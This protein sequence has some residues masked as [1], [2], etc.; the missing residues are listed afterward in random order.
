[1]I[2]G[3]E[4]KTMI[5]AIIFDLDGVITDSAQYHYLAWKELA[6]SLGIHFDETYNEKLKGISRLGSLD[7]ILEN[8]NK[9][10]EF[11]QIE[12]EA[13]AE[14]K[15]EKYKMLIQQITPAS[16]MPG[17]VDF[18]KELKSNH[19]K[20][21]IASV[22]KNAF[23]IIDRLELNEYFDTIVDSAKI[24]RSKPFPDLFLEASRILGVDPKNCIGIEDAK[25]GIEAINAAGMKSVGVGKKEQM[26]EADLFLESTAQLN[27]T[28]LNRYFST[29]K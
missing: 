8:G 3:R 26:L 18:L 6:D 13:M 19:I 20:T 22:S 14:K 21:G 2:L 11:T 7:L 27:L 1:M 29:S 24:Q 15:N 4:D 10:N 9:K 28:M 17:I 5:T 16:A 23:F 25:A 12:K